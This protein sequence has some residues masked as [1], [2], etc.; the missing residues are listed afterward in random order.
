MRNHGD[1]T[2][3]LKTG[4]KPQPRAPRPVASRSNRIV[5]GYAV[6]TLA[7]RPPEYQSWAHMNQRCHNPN[8]DAYAYYG[9]RGITVCEQWRG[10]GGFSKFLA[11]MGPRPEGKTLDRI[12]NDK[13]YSPENC[14]WATYKEQS[15][16]TRPYPQMRKP[17]D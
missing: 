4:P 8:S 2:I 10:R 3:V 16:N 9:G 7:K 1:V 14:R 6:S 17:R 11:D 13:G 12:D 15:A 5:H